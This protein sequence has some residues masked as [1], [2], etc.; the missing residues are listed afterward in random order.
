MSFSKLK[1]V[2]SQGVYKSF[3][4]PTHFRNYRWTELNQIHRDFIYT[5]IMSEDSSFFEHGGIDYE[6]ILNSAAE[7]FK[8]RKYEYGAS[9]ISQQVVKNLFLTNEKTIVRK[10]K[11]L[12]L[13]SQLEKQFN[14]NQILEIYLNI[15]EFGPELFG[16]ASASS[17]YFKK[18]PSDIN[19]AEGAFIALM[20]P[21][22]RKSYYSI[23]QNKN[24]PKAKYR[25]I[26]RILADMLANG[27][28]SPAQF[29]SYLKYHY[30][31]ARSTA[32]PRFPKLAH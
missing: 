1:E 25:K 30:F 11:E 27:Y 31:S 23:Y 6:A 12:I 10:I 26:H 18:T 7:D 24:L 19:A 28:I 3:E 4:D 29:R 14:K 20:L 17:A 15:A 32:S 9:T 16:V 13:T 2:A 22:P 8:K 5:I 21:S